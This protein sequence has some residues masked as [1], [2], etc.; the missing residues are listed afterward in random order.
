M[1]LMCKPEGGKETHSLWV[2]CIQEKPSPWAVLEISGCP[3]QM[4]KNLITSPG[5]L[6]LTDIKSPLAWGE[7]RASN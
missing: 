6:F 1:H 3:S 4:T 7:P 2:S 5:N